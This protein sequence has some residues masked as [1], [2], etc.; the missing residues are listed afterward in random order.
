MTEQRTS[1]YLEPFFGLLFAVYSQ[2]QSV[3]PLVDDL[4]LVLLLL[5]VFWDVSDTAAGQEELHL[6]G[7]VFRRLIALRNIMTRQT[8]RDAFSLVNV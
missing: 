5:A 8:V 2:H 3:C 4:Q 6:R 7:L 1:F